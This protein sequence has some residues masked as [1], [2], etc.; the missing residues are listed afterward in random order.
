LRRLRHNFAPIFGWRAGF[1]L[2]FH[3][4]PPTLIDETVMSRPKLWHKTRTMVLC[5]TAT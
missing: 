5:T 3:V 2:V 1:A 4:A